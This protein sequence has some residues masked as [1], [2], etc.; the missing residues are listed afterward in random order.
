V[1][2]LGVVFFGEKNPLVL[3]RPTPYFAKAYYFYK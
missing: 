2:S 3:G 1:N